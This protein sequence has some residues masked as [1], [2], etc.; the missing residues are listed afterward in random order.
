MLETVNI[1]DIDYFIFND[2]TNDINSKTGE[3]IIILMNYNDNKSLILYNTLAE[4]FNSLMEKAVKGKE[5][6]RL[7]IVKL[8]SKKILYILKSIEPI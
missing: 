1:K 4:R 6:Y 5:A 8:K 2:Y 7:N 3:P